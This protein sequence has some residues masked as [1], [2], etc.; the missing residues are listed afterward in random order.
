MSLDNLLGK[1]LERV[2]PNK[3][4]NAFRDTT[5]TRHPIV[6]WC[7]HTNRTR[8]G[9]TS[10]PNRFRR[11]ALAL[12]VLLFPASCHDPR[13]V[14]NCFDVQVGDQYVV[15][16]VE[17][18]DSS[19]QYA[20]SGWIGPG[21]CGDAL[22]LRP[23]LA[24]N[25]TVHG[26]DGAHS[27]QSAVV[28][29]DDFGGW[30]WT[31]VS[32][33]AQGGAAFEGKYSIAQGVCGGDAYIVIKSDALPSSPLQPGGRPSATM[34]LGFSR[35]LGPDASTCPDTCYYQYVVTVQKR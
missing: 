33:S 12:A 24:L 26:F 23:G 25:L 20:G 19:S 16:L 27:C 3:A 31:P 7:G 29:V 9:R 32:P 15:T 11:R 6:P 1:S 10:Q 14:P 30:H 17:P 34:T 8:I 28:T 18:Y 35:R 4:Y 5:F 2:E 21:T 13:D 22:G